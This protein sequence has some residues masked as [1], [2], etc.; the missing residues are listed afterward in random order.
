MYENQKFFEKKAAESSEFVIDLDNDQSQENLS[1]QKLVEIG[2]CFVYDEAGNR[3]T[4]NQLWSEFKTI[5]VFV[6]S[7]LCFTSKEYI[8]DLALIQREKLKEAQVRLVVIGCAHWKH[9]RNFRKLTKYPYLI[10]CDTDYDIYNRLGFHKNK[11]VGRPGDSPHVKSTNFSGYFSSLYRAVTSSSSFDYQG[12]L[13]QQ[14][15][16]LIVSPGPVVH[17]YHADATGRDHTPINTLLAK[18]GM[19]PILFNHNNQSEKQILNL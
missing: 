11:D 18:V 15:G 9:I 2:D 7:F 10:F 17:Y 16:S 8:E 14:G 12:D 19:K 6:R 13:Q 4:M 1:P 5:F 3:F